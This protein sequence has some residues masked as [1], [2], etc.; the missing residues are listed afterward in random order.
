MEPVRLSKT[1]GW[2]ASFPYDCGEVWQLTARCGVPAHGPQCE[3]GAYPP[4]DSAW[5]LPPRIAG[6]GL[7]LDPLP[8]LPTWAR[9][10]LA[11]A[12]PVGWAAQCRSAL[13][14]GAPQVHRLP[15]GSMWI[16]PT[17]SGRNLSFHV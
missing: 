17:V 12:V 8:A 1:A 14:V 2:A 7:D 13:T 9:P 11:P 15:A 4:G 16:T 6:A 10:S 5:H 3:R